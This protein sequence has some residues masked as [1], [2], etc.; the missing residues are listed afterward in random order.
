M[1]EEN[2]LKKQAAV[3][4]KNIL[5]YPR[6]VLSPVSRMYYDQFTIEDMEK[7]FE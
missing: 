3:A 7:E 5:S 4:R 6:S 2:W 1:T